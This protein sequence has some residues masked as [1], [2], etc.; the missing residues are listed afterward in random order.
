METKIMGN[1]LEKLARRL[2]MCGCFVVDSDGLSGGI[3]MF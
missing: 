1:I 3:G 2:G